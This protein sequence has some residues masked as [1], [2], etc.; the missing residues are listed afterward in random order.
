M[1]RHSPMPAITSPIQSNTGGLLCPSK[2]SSYPHGPVRFCA[3]RAHAWQHMA[4]CDA[5]RACHPP[6][7]A[8]ARPP[9]LAGS[10]TGLVRLPRSH[11]ADPTAP[12]PAAMMLPTR[13]SSQ[14]AQAN[15]ARSVRPRWRC[16]CAI[17]A[18]EWLENPMVPCDGWS[19][20]IIIISADPQI[21]TL[22]YIH[23]CAELHVWR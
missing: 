3:S 10:R 5:E 6:H 2:H 18:A 13:S 1:Q 19:T 16:R 14:T 23:A 4:A 8:R 9:S 17:D 15:T 12:G 22:A 21:R 11:S 7:V 20:L